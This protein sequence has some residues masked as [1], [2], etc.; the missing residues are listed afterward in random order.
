[1][2]FE[3]TP[4]GVDLIHSISLHLQRGTQQLSSNPEFDLRVYC[5]YD[6][7]DPCVVLLVADD[8]PS[9]SAE[10]P[11]ENHLHLAPVTVIA[12]TAHCL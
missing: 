2:F 11:H 7:K 9:R 4:I 8:M 5:E 12:M 6:D 1:M 10:T 3:R